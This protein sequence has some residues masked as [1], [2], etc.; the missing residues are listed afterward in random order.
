MIRAMS[1]DILAT[2]EIG[3]PEDAEAI[4]EAAKAGVAVLTTA[5]AADADEAGSRP[6]LARLLASDYFQRL[7]IL[8]A[9]KQPGT[10]RGILARTKNGGGEVESCSSSWEPCSSWPA[11]AG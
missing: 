8:D 11:R 4:A 7:V 10:V 1:P 3:R 6:I 9:R 2:D 5:H